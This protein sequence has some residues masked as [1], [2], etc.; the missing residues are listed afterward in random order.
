M[1]F[2]NSRT[3][4]IFKYAGIISIFL[5]C[6]SGNIS[7]F[8]QSAVSTGSGGQ[9]LPVLQPEDY[10]KWERPGYGVIS[11]YGK[12]LAYPVSR[13]NKENELRIRNI[14]SRTATAI[15][16][17]TRPVFSGNGNWLA[18]LIGVSEEERKKL[19]KQKKPVH[20]KMGLLQLE[21]GEQSEITDVASFSFNEDGTMLV[22]KRYLVKDRKSKGVDIVIRDLDEGTDISF[23]NISEF[24]WQPD[25]N[26]LA[27]MIDAEGKTGNGINVYNPETGLLR[28]LDSEPVQY[29][30]MVWREDGDDLA[31]LREF[32]DERYEGKGNVIIIW[33]GLEGNSQKKIFDPR[34]ETDFPADTRIVDFRRVQWTDN[35]ESVFF[36]IK[37]WEKKQDGEGS[38]DEAPALQIWHSKDVHII[39]EQEA[40]ARRNRIDSY[41]AVWHIND[42]KYIQIEDELTDRS[43]IQTDVDIVLGLD[44]TPYDIGMMFGR[45][46]SDVYVI[47]IRTGGKQKIITRVNNIYSI[48]PD[49]KNIVYLKDDHY[50]VYNIGSDEHKNITADIPDSFVNTEYDHPVE[51]MPPYGFTDWAKDG[52]SFFVNSKY[53][54]WQFWADGSRNRKITDG[55]PDRIIHRRFRLDRDA[56]YIDTKKPVY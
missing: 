33:S 16:Y 56:D 8:A 17:G 5:L 45:P 26:L 6:I 36:G 31:V 41:A 37:E 44:G 19:E 11:P 18:Y 52:K 2:N 15:P 35:G 20:N 38:P 3:V 1:K 34:T 9:Q 55:T 43:R 30:N 25:G 42:N 50:F 54:I 53:D 21:T 40:S 28:V 24:A 49:G 32:A 29:S 10:G 48:S 47:D 39:P 27:M 23:G 4:T 12:W 7:L 22:V 14:E 51:Q 46:N 13:V